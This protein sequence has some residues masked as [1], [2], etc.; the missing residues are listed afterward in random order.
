YQVCVAVIFCIRSRNKTKIIIIERLYDNVEPFFLNQNTMK[1]NTN[2]KLI[3]VVAFLNIYIIWGATFLA[4][5]IGLTGFP[6]FLLSGLRF[7]IAGLILF[8]WQLKKGEVPNSINNWRKNAIIGT[9]VLTGGVGL[10]AWGEQYVSSTEAAIAIATGPLWFII[11]DKKNW[12]LYFS[13]KFIPIGLLLGFVG[14][15]IFLNGSVNNVI[16]STVDPKNKVIA[17]VVLALSSISWVLGSLYS[18]HNSSSHSTLMNSA[19][20]LLIAGIIAVSIS[21]FKGEFSSFY[22]NAV[23]FKAW[24]GLLFLVFFGSL[25]AYLSYI[26]LISVKPAAIVSTHTYVNP[27]VAVI[28]GWLFVGEKITL[29]QFSGL[30]VILV[31]VIFTNAS[32]YLKLSTRNKVLIRRS[33]RYLVNLGTHYKPIAQYNY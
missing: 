29:V 30:T 11:I 5:E 10:V 28:I 20:Q 23:P 8:L 26:W 6:P 2:N 1:T 16:S 33:R 14:L 32:K 4:M 21:G 9:L 3:L 7:L 25:V 27:M 18:K 12:K 22:W 31:G 24:L 15:I 19:Q 17:F 13:D